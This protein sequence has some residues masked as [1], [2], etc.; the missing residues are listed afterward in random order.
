[1][2]DSVQ[3]PAS[4]D[5]GACAINQY[6][7]Y[8]DVII[9]WFGAFIHWTRSRASIEMEILEEYSMIKNIVL[10]VGFLYLVRIAVFLTKSLWSGTKAF[11]L[12]GLFRVK[13]NSSSYG[14]AGKD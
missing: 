2:M 12:S 1:M 6:S 14:W 13:L 5:I 9:T 8:S 3:H 10:L 11:I 7:L 4:K